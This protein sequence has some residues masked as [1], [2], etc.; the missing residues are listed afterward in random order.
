MGILAIH[1]I[2]YPSNLLSLQSP[3]FR[4]TAP[5][6]GRAQTRSRRRAN[7]ETR[8][9]L[10]GCAKLEARKTRKPVRAY[11]INSIRLLCATG[12]ANRL[13]RQNPVRLVQWMNSAGFG[14]ID[15]GGGRFSGV[16]LVQV[17]MVQVNLVQVDLGEMDLGE[18][19]LAKRAW[20]ECALAEV[21]AQARTAEKHVLPGGA[22]RVAPVTGRRRPLP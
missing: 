7:Q 20:A 19:D 3:V 14:G 11:R 9:A 8:K 17:D 10:A 1:I 5:G 6:N 13:W 15:F 21:G 12:G 4:R 22:P 16:N 18:M 2:P